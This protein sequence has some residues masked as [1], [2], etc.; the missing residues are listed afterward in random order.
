[1]MENDFDNTSHPTGQLLDPEKT[2]K[3]VAL[4]Q[5]KFSDFVCIYPPTS[6]Q[7]SPKFEMN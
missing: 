5:M 2:V 1:M 6:A 4:I 3:I 7:E